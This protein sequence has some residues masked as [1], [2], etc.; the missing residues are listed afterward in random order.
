VALEWLGTQ[1]SEMDWALPLKLAAGA[2]L[3]ALVLADVPQVAEEMAELPDILGRGDADIPGLAERCQKHYPAERFRCV[4]YW[5][6]ERIQ[7]GLTTPVPADPA[8]PD[9]A[10]IRR[11]HL[12]A[13]YRLL[14][15]TRRARSL[16]NSNAAPALLFEQL[17]VS[18]AR[19]LTALNS[20]RRRA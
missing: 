16:L 8:R 15:E 7:F 2:P 4:E 19:E 20:A 11:N 17:F 10:M 12:Q 18:L 13:L 14:D 5:I 1:R 9:A 6:S 3:A